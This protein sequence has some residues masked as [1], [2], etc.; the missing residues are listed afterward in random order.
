MKDISANVTGYVS[1]TLH[2]GIC[3]LL[4]IGSLWG[5]NFDM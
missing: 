5:Y 2:V 3:T 4:C 1:A